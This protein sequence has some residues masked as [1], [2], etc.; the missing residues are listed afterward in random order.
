VARTL[1]VP[2]LSTGV[3]VTNPLD[4]RNIFIVFVSTC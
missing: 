2:V 3:I 1:I 4:L